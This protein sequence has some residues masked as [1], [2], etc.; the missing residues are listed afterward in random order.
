MRALSRYRGVVTFSRM[1]CGSLA[2]AL[3]CLPLGTA[4]AAELAWSAPAECGDAQAV[5]TQVEQLIERPLSQVPEVDFEVTIAAAPKHG[6]RLEL[7]TRTTGQTRTRELAASS[8]KELKDAA[9]V[10]IAMTVRAETAPQVAPQPAPEPEREPEAPQPTAAEEDAGPAAHFA[11]AGALVLDL[12]LLPS[13]APGPE[14]EVSLQLGA[15]RLIAFGSFFPA[16]S[17]RLAGG[18]GGDFS[19]WLSGVLGCARRTFSPVDILACGGAELGQLSIEAVGASQAYDPSRWVVQLRAELG[20]SWQVSEEIGIFARAG[21]ALPLIR[22][23]FVL[24]ASDAQRVH[25]PS[26]LALRLTV[27]VEFFL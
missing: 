14:L 9:A 8:C 21:G 22:D 24:N 17:S 4:R 3:V 16:Q 2:F 7:R 5:H 26:Q 25:R 1:T 19:L 23:R 13:L 6:F 20:A 10:A 15:L 27:G 18:T 11:V 12:G